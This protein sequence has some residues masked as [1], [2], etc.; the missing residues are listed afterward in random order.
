LTYHLQGAEAW[1]LILCK[2]TR[3]STGKI[4]LLSVSLDVFCDGAQH[5]EETLAL[6]MA[7]EREN[8]I[9]EL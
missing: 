5:L 7:K 8:N 1:Y 4:D 6:C 3:I 9:N 2:Y